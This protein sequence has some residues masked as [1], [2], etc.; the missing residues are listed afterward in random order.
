[1]SGQSDHDQVHHQAQRTRSMAARGVGQRSRHQGGVCAHMR[2][3]ANV[4]GS[5]LERMWRPT[6]ARAGSDFGKHAFGRQTGSASGEWT[7]VP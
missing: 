1:M 7:L 4:G 5:R 3:L 6:H 2:A